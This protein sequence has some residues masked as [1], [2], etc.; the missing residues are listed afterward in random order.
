[1]QKKAKAKEL[2]ILDAHIGV[3]D[4]VA[5][6]TGRD[7]ASVGSVGTE[8]ICGQNGVVEEREREG[9]DQDGL[10][11]GNNVDIKVDLGL[12]AEVFVGG[13]QHRAQGAG[14][15]E[16]CLVERSG[17]NNLADMG[18]QVGVAQIV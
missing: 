4:K 9:Q 7:K 5:D 13:Q 2:E 6:S 1:M 12:G 10:D 17:E 8:A 15:D 18:G 3:P 16:R 11:V 14:E